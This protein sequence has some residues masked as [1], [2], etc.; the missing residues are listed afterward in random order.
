MYGTAMPV[1]VMFVC[2]IMTDYACTR[3]CV[4]VCVYIDGD[5]FVRSAR[6]AQVP[7]Q[8]VSLDAEMGWLVDLWTR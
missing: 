5:F 3:K 7:V 4:R 2:M 8:L 1:A 6:L